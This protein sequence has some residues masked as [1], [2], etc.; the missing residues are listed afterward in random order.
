MAGNRARHLRIVF[1]HIVVAH[2]VVAHIVFAACETPFPGAQIL[3]ARAREDS[4]LDHPPRNGLPAGL[5]DLSSR[6]PRPSASHLVTCR[7][8]AAAGSERPDPDLSRKSAFS[9]CN[10]SDQA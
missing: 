4:T 1:A 8:P 7:E 6:S 9:G 5:R 10:S 3:G 2:I